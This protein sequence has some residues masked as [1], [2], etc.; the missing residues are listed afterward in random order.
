[1]EAKGERCHW[2]GVPAQSGGGPAIIQPTYAPLAFY[3]GLVPAP[4]YRPEW[5]RPIRPRVREVRF[6][7]PAYDGAA[8]ESAV[9]RLPISEPTLVRLSSIDSPTMGSESRMHLE[10][11]WRRFG[12]TGSLLSDPDW[13]DR[14][15]IPL[16]GPYAYLEEPGE[17]ELAL[18]VTKDTGTADEA[19]AVLH[20]FTGLNARQIESL[21][22]AGRT[23]VSR[24]EVTTLG[25]GG[26]YNPV[27]TLWPR[28]KYLSIRNVG[29]AQARINLGATAG[30]GVVT[31]AAGQ[32][33]TLPQEAIGRDTV[34]VSTITGTVILAQVGLW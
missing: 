16:F 21:L 23:H 30:L 4:A 5:S 3:G 33:F 8:P 19:L 12:D 1:M 17:Y 11:G 32:T 18:Q 2:C 6:A 14:F 10:A 34:V 27:G 22:E 29:A 20:T 25:V 13:F 7:F 26:E 24:P 31:L 15:V 9:Y 28:T